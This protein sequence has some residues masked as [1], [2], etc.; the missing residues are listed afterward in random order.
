M[1]ESADILGSEAFT[2]ARDLVDSICLREGDLDRVNRPLYMSVFKE[3]YQDL[4]LS[5][6]RQTKR[7]LIEVRNNPKRIDVPEGYLEFSSIAAPNHRGLFEPMVVNSNIPDTYVDLGN[8][9]DCGC[10]CGC[11]SE[12]CSS[13]K[14]YETIVSQVVV[15][16]PDG[17]PT[18]FNASVRKKL[19]KNGNLVKE[20]IMPQKNFVN[21]VHVSTTLQK[22][23][24]FL[25]TLEI[26][27]DCG[28]IKETRENEELLIEFSDAEDIRFDCGCP[29]RILDTKTHYYK[30]S[31]NK[32]TILLEPNFPHDKVLLRCFVMQSTKNIKIPY[33]ANKAM[34]Y[35]I[36]LEWAIFNAPKE[37]DYW[38]ILYTGA[39]IKLFDGLSK[40]KITDYYVH[41]LG[42]F[43]VL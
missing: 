3:V 38:S 14:N 24:E 2:S 37:V 1:E 25:C 9:K 27:P 15:S 36:K 19:L 42:T 26:N 10:E 43:D 33:I 31:D 4:N 34:R 8:S 16:L 5:V 29:V 11:T 23:D 13:V 6:I 28:C 12:Y 32:T 18:T 41:L 22:T 17:T 39:K 30:I 7:F 21:N 40:L 35:G 20:V